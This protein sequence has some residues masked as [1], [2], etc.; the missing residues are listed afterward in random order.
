MPISPDQRRRYPADWPVISL[1]IR[2][3]R[4]RDRCECDGRCGRI[5]PDHE[6]DPITSAPRCTAWQGE[7][8]EISGEPIVLTVAHLDHDPEH[9]TDENLLAMCQ[10]CHLSYDAEHHAASR[11]ARRAA[12]STALTL[13][14]L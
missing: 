13:I 1:R 5:I 3:E 10:A 2:K 12:D 14:D 7:P 4:A 11:A 9:S 8:S 6:P